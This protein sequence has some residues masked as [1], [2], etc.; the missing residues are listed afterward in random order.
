MRRRIPLVLACG[1]LGG[2]AAGAQQIQSPRYP[3]VAR[4]SVTLTDDLL[5]GSVLMGG[6]E[7]LSCQR[8]PFDK[9][10]SKDD[11]LDQMKDQ[12]ARMGATGIYHVRY[13]AG[14]I[15]ISPRC[16]ASMRASGVAFHRDSGRGR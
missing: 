15:S 6:V 14:G 11:A 2:C 7:G 4:K 16:W 10:P 8:A 9:E 5:V 1:L 13:Q 3:P 12:A